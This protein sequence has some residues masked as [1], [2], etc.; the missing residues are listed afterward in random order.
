MAGFF[1]SVLSGLAVSA[2]VNGVSKAA[3]QS[4][5]ASMSQT[6][7]ADFE[8]PQESQ[9]EIPFYEKRIFGTP[10]ASL[11]NAHALEWEARK[12][13]ID[14]EVRV[15]TELE[16]LAAFYP[17][18]YI[19]H[20]VKLPGKVGDIDHLVVQGNTMLIVDSK[21]WKHDAAYHIYHSTFEADYLTR[22]GEEFTGGEIHLTR[23]IA[24]WQVEFMESSLDVQGVLVIA[25]RKSTVSEGINA[26]YSLANITGLATVFGNTFDEE[27]ASIMH[28]LMLTRILAM[29]QQ[30]QEVKPQSQVVKS[31]PFS[32]PVT[33]MTKKLVAWSIF[34]Y[35][36]MLLMFPLAGLSAMPLLV[37]T[38]RHQ[39]YV[40]KNELGGNGWLTAV[41]VFTYVLLVGWAVT[42]S[43]VAMYWV[44]HGRGF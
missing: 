32:K 37:V 17:N 34:N 35:T 15:A 8:V 5:H 41:L 31:A 22:D 2:L 23:Q 6:V 44:T 12:A 33:R 21:N 16:R 28:P 1:K 27:G 24:E 10:G 39:A 13:G 40:K 25:N 14:G 4:S 29:V 11:L 9:P 20:S 30:V 19:F 3:T 43:M 18:T 42:I 7:P 36:V 26:P 38:H